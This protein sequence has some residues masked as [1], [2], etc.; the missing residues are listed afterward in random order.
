M[1]F[2]D[3]C[4]LLRVRRRRT[5]HHIAVVVGVFGLERPSAAR[6]GIVCGEPRPDALS[7][8]RV[9]AGQLDGLLAERELLL[10]HRTRQQLAIVPGTRCVA[11][12]GTHASESTHV[13]GSTRDASAAIS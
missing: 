7:V 8:V 5:T 12:A 4:V 9:T 3:V 1:C 10:A 6:A 2:Y 11:E 13:W